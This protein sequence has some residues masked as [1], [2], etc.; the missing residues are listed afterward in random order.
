MSH[1][2]PPLQ[3]LSDYVILE[4]LGSTEDQTPSGILIPVTAA[5]NTAIFQ[6]FRGVSVG[7]E[8]SSDHVSEIPE[9][10]LEPG[11]I[12]FVQ[13]DSAGVLRYNGVEY[14]VCRYEAIAA[15]VDDEIEQL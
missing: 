15:V 8:C 1:Q 6:R 2:D 7:E 10:A 9:P 14:R 4:A 5:K 11:D 3:A 13:P 12:V